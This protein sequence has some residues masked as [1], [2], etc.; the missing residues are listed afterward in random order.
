MGK[1]ELAAPK[2]VEYLERKLAREKA[3]RTEAEQLLELKS[4]ELYLLNQKLSLLNDELSLNNQT[5]E[6]RVAERTEEAENLTKTLNLLFQRI[7]GVAFSVGTDGAI[8]RWNHQLEVIS[9]YSL[10]DVAEV[11]LAESHFVAREDREALATVFED[12]LNGRETGGFMFTMLSRSGGRLR[13]RLSTTRLIDHAG[14]IVGVVGIGQD[15]TEVI[16]IRAEQEKERKEASS[17]II[18]ASK[19]ATLGEMATSVAHELNQPLNIIQMAAGNSRRKLAAGMATDPYLEQKL[20]RIEDQVARAS[21]IIDHMRMFGRDAKEAPAPLDP[22]GAVNNALELM[23]EQLRL[24]GITIGLKLSNDCPKVLGHEI[25][26]EQVILNLLTNARDAI[27]QNTESTENA[28]LGKIILN[29]CSDKSGVH[30]AVSDNGGGVEESIIDRIF[31]P[32]FTT[33]EMSRG[34]GLGLSVTYGI[35]RDM[36]GS[37]VVDNIDG[38]ARFRITLPATAEAQS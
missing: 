14:N 6:K 1:S 5:L 17:Q 2:K 3:A 27:A 29:V 4:K 16:K 30:I 18:Q 24:A 19:L 38:G 12:A 32:F 36:G 25:Q 10:D 33:K 11:Q 37:I 13:I 8:K 35:I 22:R 26:L 20:L 23:G 7:N 9:G 21:A 28:E 34:T 31:E 15:I